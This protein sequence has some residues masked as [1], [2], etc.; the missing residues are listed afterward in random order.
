MMMR[1]ESSI[2]RMRGIKNWNIIF[3]R[4]LEGMDRDGRSKLKC[5]FQVRYLTMCT[6]L[7]WLR[8]HISGRLLWRQQWTFQFHRR[9]NVSLSNNH[10][11]PY[12]KQ[13]VFGSETPTNVKWI[14]SSYNTCCMPVLKDILNVPSTN[15]VL[16][17]IWPD[18]LLMLLLSPSTKLLQLYLTNMP[19]PLP[20]TYRPQ[21]SSRLP[22]YACN[23]YGWKYIVNYER[24]VLIR[25]TRRFHC[26]FQ[27]NLK[28][29]S[30]KPNPL[31]KIKFC[32]TLIRIFSAWYYV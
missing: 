31:L 29:S 6:V 30:V 18:R 17:P 14:T 32:C 11:F 27:L 22:P 1:W 25:R 4:Q 5:S 23:L 12:Q 24:N 15:S 8:L 13:L 2:T 3:R 16:E 7:I 28:L 20:S 9:R 19:R 26:H 21:S 10:V